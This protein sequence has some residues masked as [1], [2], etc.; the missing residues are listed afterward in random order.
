MA[1]A[2]D[3]YRTWLGI[4]PEEQPPNRYRLLGIPLFEDQPEAIERAADRQ[5][6]YLRTLQS[7]PYGP[8]SQQLL[9]EVAAARICLLNA[10]KK[11]AYDRQLRQQLAAKAPAPI[12]PPVVTY[13]ARPTDGTAFQETAEWAGLRE[14]GEYRLLEKLGAGGMG[15]VYKALHTEM[16]RVVAVKVL[17]S[18]FVQDEKAVARFKREIRAVASLSHPN[19]VQAHDAREIEGTRFL[20]MEYVEGMDLR[21]V[22]KRLG[23]L[24]V[25]DACELIRQ[26]ALGLQCAHEHGLVHRDIKP[27][28]LMLTPQGRSSC[29]T[30][31]WPGLRPKEARTR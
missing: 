25:A 26:A 12:P 28:N 24:P 19:I 2:F 6:A 31:V 1:G 17:P 8:L 11:A 5:V 15:D 30:S 14:L 18:G 13:A 20:V 9:S 10:E 16:D 3:P 21:D 27:G 4:A 29:W 7:G 23:P 22:A